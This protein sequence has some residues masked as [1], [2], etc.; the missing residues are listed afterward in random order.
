MQKKRRRAAAA[1]VTRAHHRLRVLV[2]GFVWVAIQI[3]VVVVVVVAIRIVV[4]FAFFQGLRPCSHTS[5]LFEPPLTRH[6]FIFIFSTEC[7]F[8]LDHLP[9]ISRYEAR[10]FSTYL[11]SLQSSAFFF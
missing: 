8:F 3:V 5:Q 1:A 6:S 4:V 2:V 7:I 11:Y 10:I 9:P